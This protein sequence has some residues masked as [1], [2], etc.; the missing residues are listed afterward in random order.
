KRCDRK[1]IRFTYLWDGDSIAEIRE[2]HDD[3]LYSVRHLVFNGFELISQQF[4]RVRQP[5]P[6]VAPQWVTRTN[7]AV[8]DLTGRPLMLFNS[9]GKTV[10][11]PGQ[12]S[13]WGLAL[14]LPAD[15]GYP[16]PRGELDPEAAPGLLYAGQWQDTESG[17]CYNRFRYY[18]PE[19]GMYLVSDPIGL[20]GGINP[21]SYV[22]NPLNWIDPLGLCKGSFDR[23]KI[24]DN[25][26]ASRNARASSNFG[27]FNEWPP[28]RGVLGESPQYTLLPGTRIDRYGSEYGTFLSPEGTPYRAR[29]LKPGTD[30]KPYSV[31]EVTK[32]ITVDAGEAAPWFGYEGGGIQYELPDKVINLINNGSLERR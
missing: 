8:S 31:Y 29:S 2:Y 20:A 3:K 32:P 27:S 22:P 6:S 14:S 5:H 15:T 7:H 28:N 26:D 12:T 23:Q 13:L 21:Y 9:E 4:S 18:E 1:K 16:D 17:L 11:R 10:W 25:I 30:G 24:L 19:T